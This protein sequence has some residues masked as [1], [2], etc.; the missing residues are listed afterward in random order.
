MRKQVLQILLV[1]GLILA[2]QRCA[3]QGVLSGGKR[4]VMP[5]KLI[6]ATPAL[7]STGFLSEMIVLKFDEFIQLKDLTNQLI[8]SPRLKTQP[9]ISAD[10]KKIIIRLKKEELSRNTTYRFYFGKSI[11][12][13]NESN[14]TPD[15]EYVFSTG[16][17]I[18]TLKV[19]GDVTEAFNNKAASNCLI[20]LYYAKELNDSMPY[21]KEP[22]FIAKSDD[23]GEFVLTHL[24]Y[25]TFK[26]FCFLDRNKNNLYDGEIE[27]IAFLGNELKLI[28]DT[29]VHF[30]MFQE[31]PSKTFIKKSTSPYFGFAQI[32]LNK[33]SKVQLNTIKVKEQ[34]NINE[35][36]I[37][38]EKDTV[39]FYYKGITDTLGLVL[40]NVIND[41]TDTIKIPIP[42]NGAAK[43]R[44]KGYTMNL[45]GNKLPINGKLKIT[46]L[47]WMDTTKKD[48][49]RIKLISKEDS[50]IGRT[51]VKG[52]W[53]SISSFEIQNKLKEGVNYSLKIDTNAFFDLNQF[54]NDSSTISFMTQNKLELGKLTLKVL[55]NKKQSYMI[56]LINEQE[57]VIRERPISFSLSSSN[58]VSI[59]FIDLVPGTYFAK[60]VFDDNKNEKWD[61][62]NILKKQQPE[63]V[64]I[65]PK[66]L[67]I[68]S[69]WEIE[70]EIIIKE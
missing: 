3:Q 48:L 37:N 18:D 45:H 35:T 19:K 68:L 53:K 1:L 13:M 67:K 38:S 52:Q 4:D 27:K 7:K 63:K 10:G 26:A 41:K 57:Q 17:F 5:P 69:D 54:T 31:T 64:I 6:E 39:S 55:L 47:T 59:D 33:K 28:S 24:P 29:N 43:K 15:F 46:F 58:S 44:L 8:I 34:P 11:A 23:K 32:I 50:L 25:S 49:S 61:S 65:N 56:Q 60:I 70:E 12:D 36:Q 40:K 30:K 21:K 66:Q 22:D 2:L 20:A 16:T 42:K 14:S 51:T 62:G 9:E